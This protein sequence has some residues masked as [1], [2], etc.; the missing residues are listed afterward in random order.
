MFNTNNFAT[1]YLASSGSIISG[2]GSIFNLQGNY[3]SYKHNNSEQESDSFA[4]YSDWFMI[5]KD[6]RHCIETFNPNT[7]QQHLS[8][9]NTKHKNSEEN[10]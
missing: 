6:I 8:V 4:I 9:W 1:D 2:A 7:E 5:G 10:P 3:F